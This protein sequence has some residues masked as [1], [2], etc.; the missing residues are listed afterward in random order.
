MAGEIERRLQRFRRPA[1]ADAGDWARSQA[2]GGIPRLHRHLFSARPGR[3]WCAPAMPPEGRVAH[4]RPAAPA[5]AMRKRAAP[6]SPCSTPA[7]AAGI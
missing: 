4:G 3:R 6:C 7:P 5:S 1:D 2:E